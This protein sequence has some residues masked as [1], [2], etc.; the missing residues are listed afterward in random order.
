M[1]GSNALRTRRPNFSAKT[2][3][4]LQGDWHSSDMETTREHSLIFHPS[5]SFNIS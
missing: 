3:C 1:I 4:P 2:G 5:Y